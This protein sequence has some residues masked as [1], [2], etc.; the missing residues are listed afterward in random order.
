M[1]RS[2]A[3]NFEYFLVLEIAVLL[4]ENLELLLLD[5]LASHISEWRDCID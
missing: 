3:V 2:L 1:L 5:H 4:G